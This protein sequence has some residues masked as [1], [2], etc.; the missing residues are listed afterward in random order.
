MAL[1]QVL[2]KIYPSNPD[3]LFK[4]WINADKRTI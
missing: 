1:K 4:E 2:A 3:K